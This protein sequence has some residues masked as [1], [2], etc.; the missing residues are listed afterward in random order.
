MSRDDVLVREYRHPLNGRVY[1]LSGKLVDWGTGPAHIEYVRDVTEQRAESE[2]ADR[3]Q[4]GLK[5][6]FTSVPC[7][8][9]V[10][11]IEWPEIVP[12]FHNP[13]FYEVVGYSDEHIRSVR[14]KTDYL[15]VHPEDVG[16][17]REKIAAA[18]HGGGSVRHSYRLW[19]DRRGEY[20]WIN[21]DGTIKTHEDGAKIFYGIYTD[22]S[23]RVHLEEELKAANE[24]MQDIVNAIPGGVAIYRVSDIFE[25][26]Y[27]S[28]GVPELT[29][30][31][32]EE[33]RELIKRDAIE[34]TY[35]EDAAMVAAKAREALRDRTVAD[36]E[37]RKLHR[38][39]HIVWVHAQA[40]QV[41]EERGRPLLQC[42]FHNIT[43]L[44]ETQL[45]LDHL[46]NSIPGGIARLP[47]GGG[48]VRPHLFLRGRAR[49]HGLHA[50]GIRGDRP[51]G[52]LR[53]RI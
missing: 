27:F 35:P 31:T 17:L 26:V 46:V 28:D 38:D 14:E 47:G 3:L 25:T 15:G 40:K 22:V 29:G 2:R 30:Y 49:P 13:A 19:N 8:L 44:K 43:A 32:V 4:E 48:A 10:Y 34:M 6:T 23:E 51:A 20:R 45:E 9:C 36:F 16:L 7:G 1:Q 24:K 33:Y 18:Y 11:R 53:R 39:G 5:E 41:G 52:R 12:L 50:G 42:V 37:F 21:L